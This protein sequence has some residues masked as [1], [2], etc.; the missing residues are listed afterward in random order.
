MNAIE[1]I[2]AEINNL[3]K[4]LYF[5]GH[6][7]FRTA[8]SSCGDASR[9]LI[10]KA[11]LNRDVGAVKDWIDNQRSL[12]LS[13]MTLID[14]RQTGRGLGIKKV[15]R[16]NKDQLISMIIDRRKTNVSN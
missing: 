2:N 12:S 11:I 16:F 9:F 3:R 6:T 13:T 14:L 4:L 5:L 8:Y 10:D 7:T 1:Q 15:D